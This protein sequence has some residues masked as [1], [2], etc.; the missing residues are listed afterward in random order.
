ML[1]VGSFE[2]K[3]HLPALLRK[4]ARG[5]EIVITNRGKPIAK[6]VPC[7]NLADEKRRKRVAKSI[8]G[9]QK[10]RDS[11]EKRRIRLGLP[12]LTQADIKVMIEEG[13]R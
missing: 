9:L 13:R 5:E 4:A 10:L 2:A 3:T 12:P 11:I 6:L 8:K 1:E 7:H